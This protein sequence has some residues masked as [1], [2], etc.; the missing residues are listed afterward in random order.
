MDP[1]LL[2]G[3]PAGTQCTVEQ[4]LDG[5]T[6]TIITTTTGVPGAP[7]GIA[8]DATASVAVTNVYTQP[9]PPTT[10]TPPTVSPTTIP[11]A[12]TSPAPP[13]SEG[14]SPLARTGADPGRLVVLAVGF[15]LLGTLLRWTTRR[16]RQ[17][18]PTRR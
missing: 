9:A 14:Q 5:D 13:P 15:A 1:A 12:T 4:V 8:V 3:L 10:N 7:V 17:H 18:L 2:G 16:S 11:P 6:P